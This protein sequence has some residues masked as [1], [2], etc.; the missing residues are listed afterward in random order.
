MPRGALDRVERE[1]LASPRFDVV[2]HNEDAS[3]F[4]LDRAA[5][6]VTNLAPEPRRSLR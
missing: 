2:Y 4:R 3:V 5:A 1:L 6:P